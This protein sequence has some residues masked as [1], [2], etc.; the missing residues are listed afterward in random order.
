VPVQT[1][2]VYD[3]AAP[4]DGYRVLVDRIWPRGKGPTEIP[5]DAWEREIAPST[6][7]R[8]WFANE[9]GKWPEFRDRYRAELATDIAA[10]VVASLAARARTGMVTLLFASGYAERN[11]AVVIREL[12]DERLA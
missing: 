8:K 2:K 9:P 11:G 10:P 12:I 6:L 3:P 5:R 1:K 4:S 7:L